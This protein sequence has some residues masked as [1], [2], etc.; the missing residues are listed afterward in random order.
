MPCGGFDPRTL[1][2]KTDALPTKLPGA[3]FTPKFPAVVRHINVGTALDS[4]SI[5]CSVLLTQVGYSNASI[6]VDIM[7]M[8]MCNYLRVDKSEFMN[9]LECLENI[10]T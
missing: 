8:N 2:L 3:H 4:F 5:L 9:S 6:K 7:I 10:I 1:H